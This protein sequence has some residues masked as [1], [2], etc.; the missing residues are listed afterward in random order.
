[1]TAGHKRVRDYLDELE[2]TKGSREPQVKEGL[3][4][5]IDLWKRAIGKGILSPDDG[6]DDALRKLDEAGG[7]YKA[8]EG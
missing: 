1:M 4:T 7:L 2:R 5:Y 3:E 6:V 8:T